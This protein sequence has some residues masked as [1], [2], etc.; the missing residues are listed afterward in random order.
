MQIFS[1]C[2]SHLK[3]LHA[4]SPFL[5]PIVLGINLMLF[6]RYWL[7]TRCPL[8]WYA[9]LYL[10]HCTVA[11]VVVCG[12]GILALVFH[13]GMP[14]QILS[15][16]PPPPHTPLS[17]FYKCAPRWEKAQDC[18]RFTIQ[19]CPR[20]SHVHTNLP[21]FAIGSRWWPCR[22]FMVNVEPRL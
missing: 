14:H 19:H 18:R 4:Q 7:S 17:I 15:P 8:F 11:T 16:P 5:F 12:F 21:L 20:T 9:L 2:V 3:Q 10:G 22:R 1:G 13:C 6:F